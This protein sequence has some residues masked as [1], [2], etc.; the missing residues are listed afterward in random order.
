MMATPDDLEDFAVGFSLA[1]GV[2]AVPADIEACET[3]VR[4]I[5][6]E[7][8]MSQRPELAERYSDPRRYLAG[9]T[10]CGLCGIES[11]EEAARRAQPV[12]D[13]LLLGS[14]DNAAA[15]EA[16]QAQHTL[17]GAPTR[18]M[19]TACGRRH[20]DWLRSV[21]MSAGT[22]RSTSSPARQAVDGRQHAVVLTSW[23]SVEMVQKAAIIGTA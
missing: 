17:T 3:V 8:R 15:I 20:R 12:G 16:M 1:E 13:G 9:P 6:I 22:M 7:L 11:L 19:R 2:I 21:R 18:S 14:G 23:V 10:G 4:D 5:G